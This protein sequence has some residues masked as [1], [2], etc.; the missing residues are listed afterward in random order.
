MFIFSKV[1]V[2]IFNI[3]IE[4]EYCGTGGPV[5]IDS[6]KR[7]DYECV[8]GVHPASSAPLL[9]PYTPT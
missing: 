6:I 4:Y 8:Q 9:V 7:E 5:E 1:L 3:Y 2:D